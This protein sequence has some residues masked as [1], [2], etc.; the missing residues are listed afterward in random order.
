MKNDY[1]IAFKTIKPFT[2]LYIYI[3]LVYYKYYNR[4]LHS[5]HNKSCTTGPFNVHPMLL[6]CRVYLYNLYYYV[7]ISTWYMN[8][9][10]NN[11]YIRLIGGTLTRGS[12]CLNSIPVAHK[13]ESQS[14]LPPLRLGR[15]HVRMSERLE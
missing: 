13:F 8:Y 6:S 3:L 9:I 15:T 5:S 14:L 1:H 2:L 11:I 7:Y 4:S 12:F 10:N